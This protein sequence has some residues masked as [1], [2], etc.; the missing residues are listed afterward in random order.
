M[1]DR[2]RVVAEWDATAITAEA[3]YRIAICHESI[4]GRGSQGGGSVEKGEIGGLAFAGMQRGRE[5]SGEWCMDW[6]EG[7]AA[8]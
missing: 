5:G 4:Y 1:A 2:S 3:Y 7:D 8:E 6:E